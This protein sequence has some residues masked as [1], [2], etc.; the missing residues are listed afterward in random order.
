[1][2]FGHLLE[3]RRPV[4]VRAFIR[5]QQQRELAVRGF[6]IAFADIGCDAKCLIVIC[7]IEHASDDVVVGHA[8]ATQLLSHEQSVRVRP[9]RQTSTALA[10]TCD[11]PS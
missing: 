6:Q 11:A 5:V 7:G 2:R 1:M 10:G 9:A 8:R 4:F 3:G